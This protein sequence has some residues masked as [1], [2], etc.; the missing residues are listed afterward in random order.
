LNENFRYFEDSFESPFE[1]RP[2]AL[3]VGI[4]SLF[5]EREKQIEGLISVHLPRA[6]SEVNV[7]YGEVNRVNAMQQLKQLKLIL[8]QILQS[9]TAFV[10]TS[11]SETS[12]SSLIDK[13]Y[14]VSK[15]HW[16]INDQTKRYLNA[17]DLDQDDMSFY[18][19]MHLAALDFAEKNLDKVI[20]RLLNLLIKRHP[21]PLMAA[22]LHHA[23]G[24]A[25]MERGDL[26]QAQHHLLTALCLLEPNIPTPAGLDV[27][28][29]LGMVYF[30]SGDVKMAMWILERGLALSRCRY[31]LGRLARYCDHL[32]LVNWK[33]D[34]SI[35][36]PFLICSLALR[37]SLGTSREV[38][39]SMDSLGR[40]CCSIGLLQLALL[41]HWR[42]LGYR[43]GVGDAPATAKTWTNLGVVAHRT[44]QC[45]VALHCHQEAMRIRRYVHDKV[46]MANS[47]NNLGVVLMK[48][49]RLRNA[50]KQIR[51]ALILR[52]E[53]N[54]HLNITRNLINLRRVEARLRQVAESKGTHDSK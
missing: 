54:D 52:Y 14:H 42:A 15:S 8:H 31:D 25:H 13:R 1:S 38:A 49:G 45:R 41:F 24:I 35:A 51:K 11:D 10:Q 33:A 32:G 40:L 29:D 36:I 16:S 46:G 2:T 26:G 39:D 4:Y 34:C 43:L 9:V 5:V 17:H 12:P 50:R 53:L 21:K 28:D 18:Q 23:L 27:L 44:N 47:H 3:E 7:L 6:L 37:L 22:S 19:E 48:M 20:A 30:Y